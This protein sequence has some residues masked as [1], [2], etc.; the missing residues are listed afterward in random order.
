MKYWVYRSP[1][2]T[3]K[4]LLDFILN[5]DTGSSIKETHSNTYI[6]KSNWTSAS[7]NLDS[8]KKFACLFEEYY[9]N[10]YY[11]FLYDKVKKH[12]DWTSVWYQVYEGKSFS[13]HDFHNHYN[14]PNVSISNVFYIELKSK[15]LLTEFVEE[16]QIIQPKACEGD[17]IIFDPKIYHRSPPN[18]TDHRKII[19]SFNVHFK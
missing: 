3:K 11:N 5:D 15:K 17:T 13:C 4:I 19:V 8:S 16:N 14:S 6:S 9:F 18:D 7:K 10:D 1:E 12:F 2:T